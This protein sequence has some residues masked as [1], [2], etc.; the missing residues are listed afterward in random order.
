MRQLI[1]AILLAAIVAIVALMFLSRREDLTSKL[2]IVEV[3]RLVEVPVEVTRQVEVTVEVTRL[4]EATRSIVVAPPATAEP[5]PTATP[6]RLSEGTMTRPIPV[7][8]PVEM[9]ITSGG[10][11]MGFTAT[12][13]KVM[14]GDEAMEVI[15]AAN[16]FNN[17][18]PDGYTF[19]L[20]MVQVIAA[21]GNDGVLQ[22][23]QFD[24]SVVT[25][26]RIIPTY[27]S[28][29]RLPCCLDPGFDFRLLPGAMGIG[30]IPLPV[31]AGDTDPLMLIGSIEG[32]TYFYLEPPWVIVN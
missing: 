22:I 16:Q 2:T 10:K 31:A 32:G 4:V 5:L 21:A 27:D 18:P 23:N 7:N 12:V 26:G 1:L 13:V 15:R 24:A 17:D 11:E 3:T 25:G 9:S 8:Q 6:T 14:D 30:W 29:Y 19:I 28:A 20:V